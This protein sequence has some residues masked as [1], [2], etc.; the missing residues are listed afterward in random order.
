[1]REYFKD[2]LNI[3]EILGNNVPRLGYRVCRVGLTEEDVK[4]LKNKKQKFVLTSIARTGLRD[5]LERSAYQPFFLNL[6]ASTSPE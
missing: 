6:F 5:A 2:G 4:D 1:M 3:S